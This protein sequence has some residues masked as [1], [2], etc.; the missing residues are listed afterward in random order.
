MGLL[1]LIHFLLPGGL[2]LSKC[3]PNHPVQCW[4]REGG[5]GSSGSGV[6][7]LSPFNWSLG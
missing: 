2:D 7:F 5:F 3:D 4:A 6:G 1:S